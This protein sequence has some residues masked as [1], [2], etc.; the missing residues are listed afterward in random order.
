[1]INIITSIRTGMHKHTVGSLYT[2]NYNHDK[3]IIVSIK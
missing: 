2:A 3:Q 1:M